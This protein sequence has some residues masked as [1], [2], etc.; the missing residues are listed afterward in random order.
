[1]STDKDN[2]IKT[3]D[4]FCLRNR[5]LP[6]AKNCSSIYKRERCYEKYLE[7]LEK[8]TKKQKIDKKINERDKSL[9]ALL[10]ILTPE[11]FNNFINNNNTNV[12]WKIRKKDNAHILPKSSYPEFAFDMDNIVV[13]SRLFHERLDNYQDP[14]TGIFIGKE[15]RKK[16][17][18]RI[19][20]ENRI[21]DENMTYDKFLEKKIIDYKSKKE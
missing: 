15:G 20:K 21:W 11:E 8:Q 18:E 16:W 10:K 5:G 6:P 13:L 3:C 12:L 2:F 7:K 1:M 17:F 4:F 19:M 14:L 9:C